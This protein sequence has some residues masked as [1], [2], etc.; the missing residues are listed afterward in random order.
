MALEQT[1]GSTGKSSKTE[2]NPSTRPVAVEGN[3]VLLAAASSAW[4]MSAIKSRTSSIPIDKRTRSSGSVLFSAGMDAWLMVQGI[5]QRLLTLPKDTV[6]LKILQKSQKR[7]LNSTEPVVR[8]IIEP[9]PEAWARWMAK[10]VGSQPPRPGKYTSL[11]L[12][13]LRRKVAICAA[14]S[15]AH[16]TRRCIV[17]IP[18]RKRKHSKGA[19]AVPSAFC[20]K[21][22]RWAR[23][24]SRT[25]TRPPVQSAWPEK[26][27]VAEWTTMSAPNDR[28]LQI[29]GGIIVES[30][31]SK[32]P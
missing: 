1:C 28:G 5:S 30:T 3:G 29:T 21:A 13:W 23:S 10:L 11:M 19:R 9:C 4:E 16:L 18:R 14:F 17:L 27:L 8:L 15:W 12:L 20:K 2:S 26:N 7:R 24:A 25:Q 31:L 6:V 32:T 22:T